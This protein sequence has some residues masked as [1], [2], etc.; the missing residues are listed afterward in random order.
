MRGRVLNMNPSTKACPQDNFLIA[1]VL[2]AKR[3]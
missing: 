3:G 1:V 2:R